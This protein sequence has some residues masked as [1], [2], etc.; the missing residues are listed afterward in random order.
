MDTDMRGEFGGLGIE[1]TMEDGVLKVAADRRH[2]RLQ[3]RHP[4]QRHHRQIDGAEV[5]GLPDQAVEKM[6]GLI[7]TQVTLKIDRPARPS[8]RIT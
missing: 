3:G 4:G 1:V 5:K 8:R 2:A 7:N 6:R